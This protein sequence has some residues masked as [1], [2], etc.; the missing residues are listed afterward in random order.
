MLL[1]INSFRRFLSLS[2]VT[3]LAVS[4]SLLFCHFEIARHKK[5]RS[6]LT[7]KALLYLRNANNN[8][9]WIT[10]LSIFS[11]SFRAAIRGSWFCEGHTVYGERNFI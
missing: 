6:M 8:R 3:Y 10:T 1:K 7:C 9:I 5:K 2:D 11:K 4:I